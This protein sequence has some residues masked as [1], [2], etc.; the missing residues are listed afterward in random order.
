MAA[1][2]VLLLV[3]GVAL[4][5]AEL[6]LPAH[7]VLATTGIVADVIAQRAFE[8]FAARM[9]S[10][11]P[12]MTTDE[13]IAYTRIPPGTFDKLA[14]RGSIPSHKPDDGRRKLYRGGR[15]QSEQP[16]EGDRDAM[17]NCTAARRACHDGRD[18][19]LDGQFMRLHERGGHASDQWDARARHSLR[20]VA[21]EA[22]AFSVGW[23]F[24]W[25]AALRRPDSAC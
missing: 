20:A 13:A 4:L 18:T 16:V 5:V 11:T 21:A 24:L 12:W 8:L 10:E 3:L 23:V 7:G 19:L 14:A 17:P 22:L 1:V 15:A 6:A 9:A 2:V 25:R